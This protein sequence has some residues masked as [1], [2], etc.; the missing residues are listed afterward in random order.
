MA[1]PLA[2]LSAGPAGALDL[3]IAGTVGWN[4]APEVILP[5]AL[6]AGIY[7]VGWWRLET[8]RPSPR[9]S[10][11]PAAGLIA[12]L[13]IALALLSPLAG[14]AHH[15]FSA[16]MTQHMLLMAVAAPLLL[17]AN[18][19]PATL[20][21]L[22]R[23]LRLGVGRRLTSRSKS[24][25]AWN[26][27]TGVPLAGL[28]YAAALWLWHSPRAYDAAL[29]GE[30]MH[31]IEH[32]TFFTAA[33]LFWWPVIGPAP[34]AL[35]PPSYG[36]RITHVVIGALQSSLLALLLSLSPRV[37]YESYAVASGLSALA[38]L[39]DQAWGGIVMWAGG[40]AVDMLA[41]LILVWRFL[42]AEDRAAPSNWPDP[43]SLR[44]RG[45]ELRV[46]K[47]EAGDVAEVVSVQRPERCAAGQGACGDGQI[48]LPLARA[49]HRTIQ[50]GGHG[51]LTGTERQGLGSREQ[52]LLMRKLDLVTRP[53]HP[54]VQDERRD[55][56][57][58]APIQ[59]SAEG[60][61]RAPGSG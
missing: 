1:H 44:V 52:R 48:E 57:A 32:L 28:I 60:G 46:E 50:A 13:S 27:L 6:L 14:L 15:S 19:F 38:P 40:A 8:R 24:R 47:V 56:D 51:G 55:G 54:L 37:L 10:W 3:G 23:P 53:A 41:V 2:G 59:D 36:L 43:A 17:L 49:R 42:A 9:L 45:P 4:R 61:C 25:S 30:W 39:E 18:P 58:L 11:R 12:V 22:P 31:H 20:W 35:R 21:A 33:L 26:V 5:L 34:R 7:A 16:H 29:G